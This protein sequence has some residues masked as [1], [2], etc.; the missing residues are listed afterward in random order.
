MMPCNPG[1][2]DPICVGGPSTL[3]RVYSI[4]M[5]LDLF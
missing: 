2:I 3:Q 5:F 1:I 4:G